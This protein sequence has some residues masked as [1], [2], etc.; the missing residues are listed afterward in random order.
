M[1]FGYMRKEIEAMT[2]LGCP[3]Q[4]SYNIKLNEKLL[5]TEKENQELKA[6]LGKAIYTINKLGDF[7]EG[8]G[9]DRR[10]SSWFSIDDMQIE[11]IGRIEFARQALKEIEER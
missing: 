5:V 9:K 6:K 8:T 11:M 7:G 3:N 10:C 1:S 2:L 4:C